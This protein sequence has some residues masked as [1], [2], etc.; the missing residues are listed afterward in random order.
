MKKRQK[1][2]RRG[3]QELGKWVCGIV[4]L[5]FSNLALAGVISVASLNNPNVN[6]DFDNFATGSI[7][8][9][10]INTTY[11]S[12]GILSLD[13]VTSIGSNPY[14]FNNSGGQGLSSD[15]ASG[16]QVYGFGEEYDHIS[17][18]TVTLDRLIT[19]IGFQHGDR[20]GRGSSFSFFNQG[21]PVGTFDPGLFGDALIFMRS[22]MAFNR[23]TFEEP[24]SWL[25]NSL[26]LQTTGEPIESGTGSGT[27]PEPSTLVLLVL[28]LAGLRYS[29]LLG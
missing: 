21:A 11:P 29:R 7:T 20:T 26:V 23:F 5:A 25:V 13:I 1:D 14:S 12:A 8:L 2:D 4:A 17:S 6:V 19:E 3:G 18:I 16:L 9:A 24:V 15:G 27:I 22:D 10:Q 28:G